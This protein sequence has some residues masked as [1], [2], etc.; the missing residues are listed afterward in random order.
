MGKKNS[1]MY[2]NLLTALAPHMKL[3]SDIG[4]TQSTAANVDFAKAGAGY[5]EALNFYKTIMS[6]DREELLKLLDTTQVTKAYDEQAR[7]NYELAPRGG[8]RAATAANLDFSKMSELNKLLQYLRGQ[9]PGQIANISQLLSGQA[10]SRLGTAVNSINAVT[11]LRTGIEQS[12]AEI[13]QREADRKAALIG[14]IIG[15][16]GTVLG[17]WLGSKGG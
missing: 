16:A 5:D 9:A 8:R 7:Q 6:G 3:L 14:S 10:A 1:D 2:N 4:G 12:N 17:G 11:G 13:Q 15:S